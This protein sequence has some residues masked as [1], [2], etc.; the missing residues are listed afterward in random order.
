MILEYTGLL[1]ADKYISLV[2]QTLNNNDPCVGSYAA[3]GADSLHSG[4]LH[5]TGNSKI[6]T[7]PQTGDSLLDAT[8]TF[9]V[10]YAP[11]TGDVSDGTGLDT[12]WADSAC[13][14]LP[15]I[16]LVPTHTRHRSTVST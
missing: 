11:G 8:K 5:A 15:F 10:C 13:V 1:S 9:A 16:F 4:A 6:V 3:G 12:T 2:D 14:P 7:V